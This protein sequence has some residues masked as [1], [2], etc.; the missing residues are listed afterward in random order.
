MTRELKDGDLLL[1]AEAAQLLRVTVKTLE[2]WEK[3]GKLECVRLPG[4]SRR[5]RRADIDAIAYPPK[6]TA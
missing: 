1:A 4:G 3:G 6:A 2:R 5:Y